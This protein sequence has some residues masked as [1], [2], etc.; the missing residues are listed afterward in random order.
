MFSFNV[1]LLHG[2]R[3]KV[4]Q[5]EIKMASQNF[6]QGPKMD[7]TED[8]DLHRCFREWREETELLVDTALAHIKDKSTKLKFVTLWAGK[9]AGTYLNTLRGEKG[10]STD[11]AKHIRRVDKTKSR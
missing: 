2:V 11:Y 8:P 6:I 4:N 3:S 10:Q 1:K 9:E 5:T 7:W